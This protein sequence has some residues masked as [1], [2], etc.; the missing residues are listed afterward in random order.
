MSIFEEQGRIEERFTRVF[1]AEDLDVDP[2]KW[3]CVLRIIEVIV[4]TTDKRT[5]KETAVRRLYISNRDVSTDVIGFIIRQHW[6]I[7]INYC[8]LIGTSSKTR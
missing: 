6:R 1:R 2:T 5:N 7:V 3:I 4:K 8:I